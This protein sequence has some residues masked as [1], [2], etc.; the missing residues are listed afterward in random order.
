MKDKL[1]DWRSVNGLTTIFN[2][3]AV[4]ILRNFISKIEPSSELQLDKR[5]LKQLYRAY[6]VHGFILN[7]RECTM[8]ELAE[9]LHAIKIHNVTGPVEFAVACHVQPYIGKISSMWL[10]VII[11]RSRD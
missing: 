1:A 9:Q 10:A 8:D 3:H 4:T 11:L 2:R 6:H 7:K 5:D